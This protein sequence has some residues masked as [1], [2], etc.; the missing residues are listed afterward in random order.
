MRMTFD[1]QVLSLRPLQLAVSSFPAQDIYRLKKATRLRPLTTGL[2]VYFVPR[3]R[4]YG[5]LLVLTTVMCSLVSISC[6][7][8]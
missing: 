1:P 6:L 4:S 2:T 5:D 3:L 7:Q 8:G